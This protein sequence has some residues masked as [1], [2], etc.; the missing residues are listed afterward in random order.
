MNWQEIAVYIIGGLAVV[1]V[2]RK[3]WRLF[4]CRD[5]SACSDCSKECPHRKS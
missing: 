5:S 1:A 4:V 2:V 3:L